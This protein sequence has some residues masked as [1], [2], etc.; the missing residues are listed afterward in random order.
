MIKICGYK[1]EL[2]PNQQQIKTFVQW[3]GA[4]RFVYNWG[5]AKKIEAY[6]ATG[7][8]P[9]YIDLSR[10]IT[11]LKSLPE[12]EWLNSPS[13][14]VITNA[15]KNLDTAYK[16]FFKRVKQGAGAKGFPKFKSRAKGLGN[17]I[18]QSVKVTDTHVI[19][20][21]IGAVRLH[22]HGYIPTS[23]VKFLSATVSEK[24]GRWFVSVQIEQEIADPLPNSSEVIGIDLGIKAMATCSNGETFDNPKALNEHTA[25]LKMWQRRL[26]RRVKG[27]ANRKKAQMKVAKIHA[28]IANIRADALHQTTAKIIAQKPQVIV[29]EDLNVSGMMKNHKLARS[30]SDVGMGEFSRQIDY[31]AKWQGIEVVYAD[32]WFPSS[33]TC[34]H[35]GN[36]KQKLTLAERIYACE[37][38]GFTVDRDLNAAINLKNTVG[39][40]GINDCGDGKL[41]GEVCL[42]PVVETVKP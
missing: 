27:S 3:C 18:V 11:Q 6:Q 40:T 7:K 33:K 21:K 41:Q 16:N 26:S 29:L 2:K 14:Q 34:S 17:F 42:V 15:L 12:F 8:S 10:D 4:G 32:K 19:L 38:C 5:L 28:K 22:R 1:S 36:V 23:G 20:P 39:I 30:I 9:S 31:K 37:V 13:R 24:A 25:K 35:C